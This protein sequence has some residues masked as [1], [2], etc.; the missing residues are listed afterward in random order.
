VGLTKRMKSCT[1]KRRTRKRSWRSMA[2]WCREQCRGQW[3][4]LELQVPIAPWQ[5]S[6]HAL[7]FR[8]HRCHRPLQNHP[9]SS[10]SHTQPPTSLRLASVKREAVCSHRPHLSSE[11]TLKTR[12]LLLHFLPTND[13]R[14]FQ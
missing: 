12:T 9:Y 5:P 4:G 13:P 2:W 11:T 1:L 10:S 6:S 3:S 8:R 14:L 7:P